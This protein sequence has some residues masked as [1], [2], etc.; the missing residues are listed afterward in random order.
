MSTSVSNQGHM[1][2]PGGSEGMAVIFADILPLRE[3]H[4]VA[5][6]R[7]VDEKLDHFWK[8]AQEALLVGIHKRNRECAE[9][10]SKFQSSIVFAYKGRVSEE[11]TRL[12]RVLLSQKVQ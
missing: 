4:I 11:R 8:E 1:A 12:G 2:L 7:E 10:K 5:R 6:L 3:S 9:S